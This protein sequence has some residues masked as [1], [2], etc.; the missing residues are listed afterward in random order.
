[1]NIKRRANKGRVVTSICAAVL[2]AIGIVISPSAK[3]AP[4]EYSWSQI[5]SPNRQ[6]IVSQLS[7]DGSTLFGY[8]SDRDAN[9][10]SIQ[11]S[12]DGG[13]TWSEQS[14]PLGFIIGMK[15]SKD[16]Q[17]IVAYQFSREEEI[18][19]GAKASY[20]YVFISRDGGSTWVK[21]ESLGETDGY[22]YMSSD[23]SLIFINGS[24]VSYDKGL[25]W[26]TDIPLGFI[27]RIVSYDGKV[28]V[29]SQYTKVDISTDTGKTWQER[30]TPEQVTPGCGET[31][32]AISGDGKML[33]SSK[34]CISRDLGVTYTKLADFPPISGYATGFSFNH[35]GSVIAI[36]DGNGSD[37]FT[38]IDGG[39]NW[40]NYGS[41]T[42]FSRPPFVSSDGS[43]I[44]TESYFA[45][46]AP[47][48]DTH[49]H[50]STVSTLPN[51]TISVNSLHCYDIVDASVKSLA[52]T[53]ATTSDPN[54][55]LLGGL[56]F[57]INC[58]RPAASS[59]ITVT[60]D[61][62]HDIAKLRVYKQ[63]SAHSQLRD[64]T[65]QVVLKNETAAGKPVTTIT[66]KATDG[67]IHDDDGIADG[68][69]TDPIF[70]G[71]VNSS[72]SATS[73][74]ALVAKKSSDRL[75]ETGA[76][77]LAIGGT[78]ITMIIGGVILARK[79][80]S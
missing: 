16:G 73:G 70:V 37:M 41:K 78:A 31:V 7:A 33:I 69:I 52:P 34:G 32:E 65:N 54:V 49:A 57:N 3:A 38:S 6:I 2:V 20:S 22:T 4:G 50:T 13:K 59:D 58:S 45:R 39:K 15:F 44:A 55:T 28:M 75:A 63:S 10:S 46:L 56:S 74:K 36:N 64:I 42:L 9:T 77:V 68:V 80:L 53:N 62:H 18:Y 79:Y 26:K 8:K 29:N 76:P 30:N 24:G 21:Q 60:L 43:V 61:S 71:V 1:M 11:R 40:K 48:E 27:P 19:G 17:T 47:G 25:T 23:G 12:T 72:F 35:D 67:A 14:T 66:Y 51:P 5:T